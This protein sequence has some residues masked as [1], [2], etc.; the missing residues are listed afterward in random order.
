MDFKEQ[1]EESLREFASDPK[2]QGDDFVESV[3]KAVLRV[4]NG[5]VV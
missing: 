2:I 3:Q 5:E 1:V 4:L